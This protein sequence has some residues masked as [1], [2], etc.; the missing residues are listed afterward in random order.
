MGAVTCLWTCLPIRLPARWLCLTECCI[1]VPS[2]VPVPLHVLSAC[3]LN[4]WL[5]LQT[6]FPPPTPTSLP[7][8]SAETYPTGA[9]ESPVVLFFGLGH[10]SPVWVE[11]GMGGKEWGGGR[12]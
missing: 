4:Q 9:W 5:S 10:H 7:A 2:T 1:P 8:S 11:G 12:K 3:L 6:L